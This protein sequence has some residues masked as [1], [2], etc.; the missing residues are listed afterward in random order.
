MTLENNRSPIE[1]WLSQDNLEMT[2]RIVFND[3]STE[4]LDVQSLSMRGAQREMTG[5]LISQGY[6]PVG[7]WSREDKYGFE[8]MRRFRRPALE[9]P[10]TKNPGEFTR[11]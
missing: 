11:F 5:W 7:R 2:C 1:V 10:L 4:E 6:E 9:R 3:E 8:T